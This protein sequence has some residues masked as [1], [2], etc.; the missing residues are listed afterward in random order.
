VHPRSREIGVNSSRIVKS[1]EF[2]VCGS[3]V[4]LQFGEGGRVQ[5]YFVNISM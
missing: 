3:S 2:C 1:C 5:I 4:E